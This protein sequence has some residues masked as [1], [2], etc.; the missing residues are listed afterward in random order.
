VSKIN[1]FVSAAA[2]CFAASAPSWAQQTQAPAQSTNHAA[3]SA[4]NDEVVVTGVHADESRIDRHIYSIRNDPIA[5]TS[6]L[7]DIL[8]RLPAITVAP[9]GQIRLLGV[10]PTIE[11]DGQTAP[12]QTLQQV[13]RTMTGD[14]IERIEVITNPSAQFSAQTT[15]GIINIVTRRSFGRGLTGSVVT[16]VDTTGSAVLTMSPNWTRGPFT[17]SGRLGYNR[18]RSASNASLDR[19]FF[20]TPEVVGEESRSRSQ[21]DYENAQLLFVYRPD[22]RHRSSISYERGQSDSASNRTSS[23]NSNILGP[24]FLQEQQGSNGSHSDRAVLSYDWNGA[25]TGESLSASSA[26]ARWRSSTHQINTLV[27][28]AG[29]LAEFD[30]PARF[31]YDTLNLKLDY[32]RPFG[33]RLFFSGL[34]FDQARIDSESALDTL[35]GAPG[36]S[37]FF[38]RLR[39]VQSTAAAYVTY[40][41]PIGRWTFLPGARI[42]DFQQTARTLGPRGRQSDVRLLPTFHLRRN[43]APNLNFDLS[44]TH[45][46]SHPQLSQIDPALHFLDAK[47]AIVGNPDLRPSLTGAYEAALSYQTSALS[48]GL[49]LYDRMTDNDLGSVY[50]LEPDGVL[51]QTLVNAGS[52]ELR[53]A[54]LSISQPLGPLWRL[55][56]SANGYDRA[57]NQINFGVVSRSDEFEYSGSAQLEYRDLDQTRVGATDLQF[58]IQYQSPVHLLATTFDQYATAVLNWR[59][60][61][62]GNLAAQLSITDFFDTVRGRSTVRTPAFME[63]TLSRNDFGAGGDRKIVFTLSYQLGTP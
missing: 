24:L 63:R 26:L 49:T 38:E 41:F 14:Q 5:Q 9:S 18:G 46:I 8:A 12:S 2:A 4:A 52:D 62:T 30:T 25:H 20:A 44:Y 59:R 48:Y 22:N 37:D 54:Q 61:L 36:P 7:L 45:R 32:Q 57:S 13:L 19:Q 35:S 11:I 58:G 16:G 23:D 40:Q 10:Q 3:P 47:H 39:G 31:A 51:L 6:T 1:L 55:T 33:A 34:A 21:S 29:P 15:G 42:E 53:G 50:A 27:P 60:R 17:L 28:A 43:L 56:F